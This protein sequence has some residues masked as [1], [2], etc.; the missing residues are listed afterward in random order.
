MTDSCPKDPSSGFYAKSEGA[1]L[2]LESFALPAARIGP[3]ATF[4]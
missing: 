3:V 4:L 2:L 1:D